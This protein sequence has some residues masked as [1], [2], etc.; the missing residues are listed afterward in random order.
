MDVSRVGV[1]LTFTVIGNPRP[2]G[3]SKAFPFKGKD[4]RL[5]VAVTSMTVGLK[6][7]EKVVKAEA[8]IAMNRRPVFDEPMWLEMIFH[9]PR[10]KRLK[11]RRDVPHSTRPDFSKLWRASE[12]AL[13]GTVFVDDGLVARVWGAKFYAN[14]GEQPRVNIRVGPLSEIVG[15]DVILTKE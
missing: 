10:P 13:I 11:D 2:K 3:S 14:A 12:D 6:D 9:L 8:T 4:G 15:R 1:M 5:H 7:W